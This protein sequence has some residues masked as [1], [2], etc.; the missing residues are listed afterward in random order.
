MYV[1]SP[2]V[3]ITQA[4]PAILPSLLGP[5]RRLFNFSVAFTQH[6]LQ[7][8]MSVP[9][10]GSYGS[11]KVLTRHLIYF[12]AWDHLRQDVACRAHCICQPALAV[13]LLLARHPTP[14]HPKPQ[15][16]ATQRASPTGSSNPQEAWEG[17]AL[18]TY[19]HYLI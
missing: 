15:Q 7:S 2:C 12:E 3:L 5:V 10:H 6:F 9:K 16:P 17:P 8:H 19:V 13:R 1:G 14:L 4:N 18:N 11:S